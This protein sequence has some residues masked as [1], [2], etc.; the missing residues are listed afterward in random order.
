MTAAGLGALL[1]VLA[2]VAWAALGPG[3]STA[4]A[5]VPATAAAAAPARIEATRAAP[6]DLAPVAD[7]PR[8]QTLAPA[9]VQPRQD[10]R[11]LPVV[12]D[13]FTLVN[14]QLTAERAPAV[15]RIAPIAPTAVTLPAGVQPLDAV[16]SPIGMV[17]VTRA[18]Q[19]PAAAAPNPPRPVSVTHSP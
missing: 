14:G 17:S 16:V 15:A 1:A 6:R 10:A 2:C 5:D 18:G 9:P 8:A 19:A 12:P 7:A 4:S 13:G 3:G 11:A